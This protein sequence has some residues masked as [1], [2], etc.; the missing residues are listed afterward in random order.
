MLE[1]V[2]SGVELVDGVGCEPE[3]V[4]RHVPRACRGARASRRAAF[5]TTPNRLRLGRSS[6]DRADAIDICSYIIDI[7]IIDGPEP[8]E[9]GENG[10]AGF[11]RRA[12]VA[13]SKVNC[14]RPVSRHR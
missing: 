3:R 4:E 8:G 2:N 14:P 6:I 9:E 12:P 7:D 11:G 1:A 13:A 5:A 10:S